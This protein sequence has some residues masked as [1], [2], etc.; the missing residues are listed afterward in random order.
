VEKP[1]P[2]NYNPSSHPSARHQLWA[3]HHA[4]EKAWH[5]FVKKPTRRE[6]SKCAEKNYTHRE[7]EREKQIGRRRTAVYLQIASEKP[8]HNVIQPIT[9]FFR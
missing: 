1:A 6:G 4:F 3:L 8:K 2:I 5:T 7:R 9:Y